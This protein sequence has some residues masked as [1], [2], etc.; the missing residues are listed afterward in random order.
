MQGLP[1]FYI[2][3]EGNRVEGP[4]YELLADCFFDDSLWLT[5]EHIATD[6]TPNHHMQPLNKAAGERIELWL[7]TLPETGSNLRV[8]DLLEA[9]MM[10]RP[11]EGDAELSSADFHAAVLRRASQLKAKREGG[12]GMTVPP[13]VQSAAGIKNAPA[14][15][16][17]NIGSARGYDFAEHRVSHQPQKPDRKVRR[18]KDAMGSLPAQQSMQRAS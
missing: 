4:V 6:M 7:S 2:S 8:D 1:D 11:K 3:D 10:L 9:A 14:M 18:P 13:I 15:P 17:A 12:S 16:N 5:G